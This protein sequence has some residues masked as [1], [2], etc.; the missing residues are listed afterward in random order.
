MTIGLALLLLLAME[1]GKTPTLQQAVIHRPATVEERKA[2][3]AL[4]AIALINVKPDV[5]LLK[6]ARQAN[7]AATKVSYEKP[8]YLLAAGPT[9]DR[10]DAVEVHCLTQK[11]DELVLQV[12]HTSARL[13]GTPLRR[14]VR[15]RPLVQVPVVL[16]PGKWKVRIEWT[17]YSK[18]PDGKP[19]GKPSVTTAQVEVVKAE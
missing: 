13:T 1:E 8:L 6:L 12:F 18:L 9:L 15:W 3:A 5:S 10:P 4:P 17:P 7:E 11:D 14:N 16:A 2:F 19:L